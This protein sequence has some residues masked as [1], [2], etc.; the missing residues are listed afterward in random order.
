VIDPYVTC[1]RCAGDGYAHLFG[2]FY[3]WPCKACHGTGL[4][5]RLITRIWR[6]VRHGAAA[7]ADGDY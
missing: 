5:E 4:R 6:A 7:A 3:R 2:P 1:D